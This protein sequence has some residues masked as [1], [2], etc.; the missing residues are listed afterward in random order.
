[1]RASMLGVIVGV[2]IAL[3]AV[4]IRS[5]RD[6]VYAQP[7]ADRG[8]DAIIALAGAHIDGQQLVIV[9]D[10]LQRTL[11]SYHVD[12]KTGRVALRGVRNV[13]WDLRMDEFNGT[14]P[15][16]EQIKALLNTR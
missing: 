14:E 7:F 1:M 3:A 5:G 2:G 10:P 8:E 15:T 9:I 11:G 4:G 16:P 13:G 6:A 12:I